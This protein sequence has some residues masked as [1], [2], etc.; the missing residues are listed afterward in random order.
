MTFTKP[1]YLN[2]KKDLIASQTE[3]FR[4]CLGIPEIGDS[5]GSGS[6]EAEGSGS[7]VGSV[8]AERS[9]SGVIDGSGVVVVVGEAVGETVVV[10][11]TV[12]ETVGE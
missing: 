6:V 7:G 3:E 5:D 12:G 2:P 10:G 8:E 9:G 11:D 1:C 4:F